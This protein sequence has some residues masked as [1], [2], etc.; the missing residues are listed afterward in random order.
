MIVM[1]DQRH[2]VTS[3]L[4]EQA[5]ATLFWTKQIFMLFSNAQGVNRVQWQQLRFKGSQLSVS[6]L[7]LYEPRLNSI[8]TSKA[9]EGLADKHEVI[10]SGLQCKSMKY[11]TLE[12]SD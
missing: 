5:H 8:K 4:Q 12:R 11:V 1:V 3:A 9:G 7:G 2:L 6:V 10:W